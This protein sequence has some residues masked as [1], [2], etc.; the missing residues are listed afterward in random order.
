MEPTKTPLEMNENDLLCDF[1]DEKQPMVVASP[2]KKCKSIFSSNLNESGDADARGKNNNKPSDGC[3]QGGRTLQKQGDKNV[4]LIKSKDNNHS[5]DNSNGSGK[6]GGRQHR[7]VMRA[8]KR[9]DSSSDD[10]IIPDEEETKNANLL[11]SVIISSF[12]RSRLC[13]NHQTMRLQV[14]RQCTS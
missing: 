12:H 5:N 8:P 14:T 2:R 1:G 3:Q 9:N 7:N 4:K 13:L 10:M 11:S 6:Q